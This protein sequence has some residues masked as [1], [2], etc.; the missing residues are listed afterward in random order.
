MCHYLLP[1]YADYLQVIS[2]LTGEEVITLGIAEIEST[3]NLCQAVHHFL[4]NSCHV[5]W[6]DGERDNCELHAAQVRAAAVIFF[7][8]MC[9]Q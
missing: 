2:A 7:I 3:N 8:H 9:T 1:I 5:G 4:G 6:L